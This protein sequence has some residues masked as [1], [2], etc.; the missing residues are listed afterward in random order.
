MSNCSAGGSV[1]GVGAAAIPLML[2]GLTTSKIG[3]DV[4]GYFFFAFDRIAVV[5]CF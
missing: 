5:F 3:A 2:P 1:G 4:C